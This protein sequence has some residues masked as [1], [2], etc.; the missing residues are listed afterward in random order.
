MKNTITTSLLKSA[1]DL[2]LIE[3]GKKLIDYPDKYTR[4]NLNKMSKDKVLK[5]A[6]A[7]YYAKE[8]NVSKTT[9]MAWIDEDFA[10]KRGVSTII[11]I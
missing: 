7:N 10:K 8:H 3:K 4:R 2:F 6:F 11:S 9:V 5:W 1:W